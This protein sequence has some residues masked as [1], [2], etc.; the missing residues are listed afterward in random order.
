MGKPAGIGLATRTCT[1]RTILPGNPRVTRQNKPKNINRTSIEGD[2]LK[3]IV[4]IILTITQSKII[5][6][7]RSWACS[8]AVG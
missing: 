8:K 7:G 4:F 2:I 1:R 6:L 3:M 5:R